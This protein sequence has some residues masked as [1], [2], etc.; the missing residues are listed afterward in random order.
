MLVLQVALL[1]SIAAVARSPQLAGSELEDG[2][3]AGAGR[4]TTFGACAARTRATLTPIVRG[5]LEEAWR[6]EPRDAGGELEGEPLVWGGRVVVAERADA[7]LRRLTALDLLAGPEATRDADSAGR[8]Q[9]TFRTEL[10]LEANLW[11][12][13]VLVRSAP[14]ELTAL[15][16][17]AAG[18]ETTWSLATPG[19]LG[20]PLLFRNEVYACAGGRLFRRE[21]GVDAP[22]WS[23][24]G[25]FRG[26][27]ALRGDVLFALDYDTAGNVAL[28]RLDRRTGRL[29]SRSPVGHHGG[30]R[31]GKA[32]TGFAAVMDS[33]VLLYPDFPL[34]LSGL[35]TPSLGLSRPP[36]DGRAL[37][38]ASSSL[39]HRVPAAR[40]GSAW[41]ALYQHPDRGAAWI[42]SDVAG[43][44]GEREGD[45][46]GVAVLAQADAH[47]ELCGRDTPP[48]VALDAGL[49]GGTAFE[50]DGFEVLWS[51]P[52]AESAALIPARGAVL[53]S[54]PRALVAW[55]AVDAADDVPL[56][57]AAPGA[58]GLARGA[59]L[60]LRDGSVRTA[61]VRL[62][63][64]A[65][66]EVG[67]AP[68]ELAL[69]E[70]AI[71]RVALVRGADGALLHA[72]GERALLAACEVLVER[73]LAL[74]YARLAHAARACGDADLVRRLAR[75]A[76]E[77]GADGP[78]LDDVARALRAPSTELDPAAIEA[79]LAGERRASE[80]AAAIPWSLFEHLP[81]TAGVELR[82]ELLRSVLRT[83]PA[84]AGAVQQVRAALPW[85]V[86]P[87]EHVDALDWID[88]LETAAR[89]PVT[90][91]VP[92]AREQGR[93]SFAQRELAR[94]RAAWRADL[95]AFESEHLVLITPLA[96]PGG[97]ARCLATGE[98]VCR[99]LEEFFE[100]APAKERH[101]RRAERLVVHLY[102]SDAEYLAGGTGGGAEASAGLAWS[103]G[104]YD[105][106]DDLSRVLLPDEEDAWDAVLRTVAHE[107]AHHWMQRLCPLVSDAEVRGQSSD[108][109]GYWVVEGF[110]AL[111]EEQGFDLE[112]GSRR[113][114]DPRGSRLDVLVHADPDEL[115]PWEEVLAWSQRDFLALESQ[116]FVTVPSTWTLGR[117]RRLDARRLFY[118]QAAGVARHLFHS[119][120][121]GREALGRYLA[122]YYS[123]RRR[124]L[125]VRRALGAAPAELGAL[126]VQ[127]AREIQGW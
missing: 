71:D 4:W 72:G 54:T 48:A 44:R 6:Y 59:T 32:S 89:H 65:V 123:G 104:H 8:A 105:P 51:A 102:D 116:G 79:A 47:G 92:A 61:D 12:E 121:P 39:R 81:S 127:R 106:E 58:H 33:E 26:R 40:W 45:G 93:R 96:R 100:E 91:V 52:G 49:L 114:F 78:A 86:A 64:G 87:D 29:L 85:D 75:E 21:L 77:H 19:E 7:R 88:F 122:D 60:V 94:A 99:A 84:H 42:R 101:A 111:F 90:R 13:V 66:H 23:T 119:G 63:A 126:A 125:D 15:R 117:R 24:S 68:A 25:G 109:P 28:A 1:A 20:P 35:R 56:A 41:L 9:R 70:L 3:V 50:L 17:G 2:A 97:I 16:V 112:T 36:S 38:I 118:D 55:R 76:L 80:A 67:P 27:L 18:L 14:R 124:G 108:A 83:V 62:E 73:E 74:R 115:L 46:E 11:G 107:L 22:A 10:P 69:A 43:L 37:S 34:V 110:A 120:E 98:L 57:S 5:D 53:A 103:A 113:G 30:R 95:S 82:Y 31:P